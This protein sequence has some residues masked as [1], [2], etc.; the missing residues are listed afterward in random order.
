MAYPRLL[1]MTLLA[2]AACNTT[3]VDLPMN[4]VV[5]DGHV[6][7]YMEAADLGCECNEIVF[8]APGTCATLTD[9]NPCGG[10]D[11]CHSCITDIGVELD[12]KRLAP[13]RHGGKDPWWFEYD[14]F[15]AGSLSVVVEGCG[16][17]KTRIPIDGPAFPT[18]TTVTADYD[19]GLNAHVTWTSDAPPGTGAF[20][21]L[22]NTYGQMCHVT[23][24]TEFTA[25][26]WARS[27]DAEVIPL[28]SR[29]ELDTAVGHATIWRGGRAFAT[30]P[31]T[32]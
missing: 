14:P 31:T 9:A 16:H 3:V 22:S 5:T 28:V 10:M 21:S 11:S 6:E 19:S 30:F 7:I 2:L 4:I 1:S 20:V 18:T 15:A 25:D 26:G 24:G 32:P 17:P 23:S 12:G 29:T 13:T 27:L 8:P